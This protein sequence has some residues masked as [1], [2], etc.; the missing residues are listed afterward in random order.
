MTPPRLRFCELFFGY[1]DEEFADLAWRRLT[2]RCT[3]DCGYY[4]AKPIASS[5]RQQGLVGHVRQT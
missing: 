1:Q 3:E 2:L 5:L 4:F